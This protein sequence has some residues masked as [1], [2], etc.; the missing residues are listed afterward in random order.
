MSINWDQVYI[1][2]RDVLHRD[3]SALTTN[4]LSFVLSK[5]SEENLKRNALDVGCGTG[6]VCRDLFHR[7]FDVIGIDLSEEAL[8]IAKNSTKYLNK[9][10][11]FL[12]CDVE[13]EKLPRQIAD[14]IICKDTY[15]FLKDKEIF[16]KNILSVMQKEGLLA[17]ISPAPQHVPKE[18]QHIT[19]DSK[20]TIEKLQPYFSE[21]L[22]ECRGRNDYYFCRP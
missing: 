12:Q 4:S 19:V 11:N 8:K 18:K 17:I 22:H 5:L 15:A 2:D 9:G 14:L 10:I 1:R 16:I 13:T 20:R 7:G 6:Q 3:Y 21:V